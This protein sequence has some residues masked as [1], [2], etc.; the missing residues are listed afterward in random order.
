MTVDEFRAFA[1]KVDA[2]YRNSPFPSR[3][4]KNAWWEEMRGIAFDDACRALSQW[5]RSS[6][7]VPTLPEL[8]SLCPAPAVAPQ[9]ETDSRAS[10]RSWM[11]AINRKEAEDTIREY[12][13]WEAWE[14]EMRRKRGVG[15]G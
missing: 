9:G 11:T 3:E 12:G 14:A 13:S 15:D 7:Y 4:A 5:M 6:T 1:G 2:I 8:L 10:D